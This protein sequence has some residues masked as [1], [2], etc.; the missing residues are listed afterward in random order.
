MSLSRFLGTVSD[1]AVTPA[2]KYAIDKGFRADGKGRGYCPSP[3]ARVRRMHSSKFSRRRVRRRDFG[4]QQG[5]G[6][7][8]GSEKD[9]ADG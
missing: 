8:G 7:K 3:P 2:K 6:A 1:N 5:D 9:G 4:A